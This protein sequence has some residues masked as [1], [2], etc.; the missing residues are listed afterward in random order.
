MLRTQQSQTL[1]I[2]TST[3]TLAGIRRSIHACDA[4]S[5]NASVPFVSLLERLV[6]KLSEK[7][8]EELLGELQCPSCMGAID[9]DSRVE[10][11]IS[12]K[13]FAAR[14]CA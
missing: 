1:S 13:A 14:A 9:G 5:D 10:V 2:T 7:P 4:C 6:G 3:E 12:A 8:N 11:Q